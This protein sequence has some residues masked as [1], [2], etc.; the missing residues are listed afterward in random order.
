MEKIYVYCARKRTHCDEAACFSIGS[1]AD[2]VERASPT[3]AGGAAIPRVEFALGP[4]LDFDEAG[5]VES[6]LDSLLSRFRK[7]Q[8][9]YRVNPLEV[10]EFWAWVDAQILSVYIGERVSVPYRISRCSRHKGRSVTPKRR[11]ADGG[12]KDSNQ[13]G[14]ASES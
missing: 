3:E 10:P 8:R 9:Q 7:Q 12:G 14:E 1:V 11:S 5:S 2:V 4:F 6:Q 13:S